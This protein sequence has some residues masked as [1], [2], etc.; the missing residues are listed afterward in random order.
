MTTRDPRR[1][2]FVSYATPEKDEADRIV[3]EIEETEITCWMVPR[4]VPLGSNYAE[5]IVDA[6]ERAELMVPLLSSHANASPQVANEIK[7]AVNYRKSIVTDRQW[8]LGAG[9]KMPRIG[10]KSE[11]NCPTDRVSRRVW[12]GI[13]AET[14]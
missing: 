12:G 2:V 8:L 1:L 3:G 13:E 9:E 10:A 4:D 7:R 14:S 5:S 11:L 6:I